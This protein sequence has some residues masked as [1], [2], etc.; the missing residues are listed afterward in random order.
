M[1]LAVGCCCCVR[2]IQCC[3]Q[4]WRTSH[5]RR[6]GERHCGRG[7]HLCRGS[8]PLRR[9]CHLIDVQLAAATRRPL[10]AIWRARQPAG[11]ERCRALHKR[12]NHIALN[13]RASQTCRSGRAAKQRPGAVCILSSRPCKDTC[14]GHAAGNTINK[15]LLRSNQALGIAPLLP[16]AWRQCHS[17]AYL[18]DG[19]AR[20]ARQG[21][22]CKNTHGRC[23]HVVRIA[24]V[25]KINRARPPNAK[26][27]GVPDC[28][29]CKRALN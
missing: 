10:C 19:R 5:H 28:T 22:T 26:A 23:K 13:S 18:W 29:S 21:S 12:S 11:R 25:T 8:G 20:G 3:H 2:N 1:L 14:D 6:H 17:A 16:Q 7:K 4:T 15:Q 9:L 27:A 24:K